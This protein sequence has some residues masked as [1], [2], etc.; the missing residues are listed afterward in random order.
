[1]SKS[2]SANLLTHIQGEVATLAMCW[3]ITRKD[4]TVLGFTTH[5]E[6]LTVSS[7]LYKAAT[8][9]YSSTTIKSTSDLSVDNLS[10]ESVLESASIT[11]EDL[12][13]G[14]YDYAAVEIFLVNYADLTQGTLRLRS[15]TLGEVTTDGPRFTT[16]LRGITQRL[17]QV[18][19]RTYGKRC[20]ADLFD[21]RCTVNPAGYTVNGTVSSFS[22]KSVFVGS[23]EPIR[24]GGKQTWTSGLNNGLPMEIKSISGSTITLFQAM[25]YAIANGD[26]YTALA[27]C[28]KN[29]STCKSPYNNVVN[30]QG[31]PHI[32]GPDK[33]LS[34]PDA[35]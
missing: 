1:M 12:L 16:E 33:A 18:I 20:D 8:G 14:K 21:S 34:Y 29:L 26:A 13:A 19:G 7:V 23:A 4:T 10:L 2:I 31:F 3:K 11:E 5:I 30:F 15:G 32:P 28:D 24:P 9:S 17:Q 25:P 22:S 27:G 35:R 6:D